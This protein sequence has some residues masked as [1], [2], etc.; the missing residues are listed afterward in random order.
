[1][2]NYLG[3]DSCLPEPN[4]LLQRQILGME[5]LNKEKSRDQLSLRCYSFVL[6]PSRF[7]IRDHV[8]TTF[9]LTQLNVLNL[10]S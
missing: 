8:F 3:Y 1:M 9:G 5:H 4:C 10:S 2:Y 7:E 6:L